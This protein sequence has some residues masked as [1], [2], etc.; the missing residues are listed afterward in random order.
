MSG[1]S[2]AGSTSLHTQK[3]ERT[4]QLGHIGMV[5]AYNSRLGRLRQEAREFQASLGHIVRPF[6]K[7]QNERK[8]MKKNRLEV[9]FKW[10]STGRP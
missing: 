3:G 5:H 1:F 7:K 9:C 6:F 8:K 4:K 2:G 10:S